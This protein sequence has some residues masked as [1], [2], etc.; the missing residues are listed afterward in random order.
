MQKALAKVPFFRLLLPLLGG[1]IVQYYCYVQYWAI[2]GLL[3]GA[4]IIACSCF[5]R[6]QAQYNWRWLF[7]V[8]CYLLLFSLGIVS[9]AYRQSQASFIFPEASAQYTGIVTDIPQV[10]PKTIA[11]NVQLS[12]YNRKIVCYLPV[13]VRSGEVQAGDKISFT[14]KIQP[15]GYFGNPDEFDYPRYMYNKGFAGRVFVYANDW[16]TTVPADFSI[17]TAALKCRQ[18]ILA[19]YQSLEL[20][21]EE[22]AILSALTL[23]YKDSL[24][25]DLK[26]SFR[27]TGTAHVLAVSGMHAGIIYA[28]VLS[29]LSLFAWLKKRY[30]LLQLLLIAILWIYAFV[31]GFSP[32]V[33]RATMM[34]SVFC[35]AV[36]VGEKGLSCNN[37]SLAAFLMLLY[38]PFWLF[39]AGFRLSFAAVMSI[40]F[41]HPILSGLYRPRNRY[42]KPVWN[43]FTLSVA[44]QLGTCPVCLCYFG[45]FPT[46]FFITN[47]LVVPLVSVIF[48]GSAILPV[49]GIL[50]AILP[51]NFAACVYYLPVNFL[52]LTITLMT[53]VVRFFEQL[54]FALIENIRLSFMDAL[55]LT[56]AI[57]C[58]AMFLTRKSPRWLLAALS[59]VLL[60]GMYHVGRAVVFKQN[61][62]TVYPKDGHPAIVWRRGEVEFKL[63]SL[64]SP[65]IISLNGRK[66]LSV[67]IDEWK[68]KR[69][70]EKFAVDYVHVLQGDDVSLYSLTQVLHIGAVVIDSSLSAKNRRKLIK[71][72]EKL[73]IPYYDMSAKGVFRINF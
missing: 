70:P 9:T 25:D 44:V 73:R 19:F 11:C 62:L 5:I 56:A 68:G 15:F 51:D 3:S 35:V 26:Q 18:S 67:R 29:L 20:D 42:V 24:S 30:W 17:A 71:E 7:G 46:Y 2:V 8:G 48:Y 52:K 47:L 16:E 10:K 37:L 39:D 28:V 49:V 21:D 54:P 14:G 61:E 33:V 60:G 27:A 69:S 41:F 66:W 1:I 72:C 4:A 59:A 34:L 40:L 43:L 32:S 12:G 31:T 65:T 38:N 45:T 64:T 58:A 22:Y 13:G 36:I 55:W 57:V 6:P 50:G 63:D 53:G 23:G